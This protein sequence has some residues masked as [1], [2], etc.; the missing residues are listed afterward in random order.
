MDPDDLFKEFETEEPQPEPAEAF[1]ID[2]PLPDPSLY[3]PTAEKLDLMKKHITSA[4]LSIVPFLKKWPYCS[5]CGDR[6]MGDWFCWIFTIKGES[7]Q[8]CLTCVKQAGRTQTDQETKLLI[9]RR[10]HGKQ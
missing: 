5:S 6:L 3:G 7:M 9:T 4:K 2:E 8:F 10:K 1:L